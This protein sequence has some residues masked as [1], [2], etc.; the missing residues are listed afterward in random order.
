M[1]VIMGPWNVNRGHWNVN[2]GPGMWFWDSL[3]VLWDC[4]M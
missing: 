3:M 4:G 1:N 2:S